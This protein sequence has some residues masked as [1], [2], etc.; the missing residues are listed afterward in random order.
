MTELNADHVRLSKDERRLVILDQTLLPNSRVY[1]ELETAEEM[2]EAIVSLRIRGAP[3]LG[4]FAGFAMYVLAR[5]Y[6]KAGFMDKFRHDAAYLCSSRPTAVNLSRAL[7]RMTDAAEKSGGDLAALRRE[8]RAILEEDIAM[9]TAISRFGLSLLREGS[10]VLTHCNAGPIATSRYGTAIGPL[11]MA[12]ERGMRVSAYCDETRPLL[13]GARLTAWE[14]IN[15]GVD[16]TL[17]CDN[18]S[19]S[20]MAQGKIDFCFVGCDRVAANGDTAN[21]IGTSLVAIAAKYYGIPFYVLG[22]TSS[23]DLDCRSGSDIVIE[24]RDPTEI[25]TLW[26]S[27]PMAPEGVRCCNPAFDVTDSSLITG[28]ITEKGICRP[29]YTESLGSLFK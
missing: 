25:S 17:I 20:V 13:Q 2:Y 3:A 6:D 8:C 16:V 22:P 18:M 26:Y 4:I 7:K 23:V 12:A 28:I 19:A 10:T 5:G 9:C 29:P 15:A 14:L 21:K 1:I 27:H 11:I 24:Q